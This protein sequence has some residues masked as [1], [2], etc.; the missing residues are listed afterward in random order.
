MWERAV[1]LAAVLED[2]LARLGEAL[3]SAAPGWLALG[4]VLHLAN[5]VARGRGWYA[6]VSHACDGSGPPRRRDAVA[7]WIAGAGAGGVL[8]ARGGDAVRVYLLSRRAPDP[9]CAV[10]TGTLVAEAAGELT[11]GAVIVALAAYVGT[12]VGAGSPVGALAAAA[13]VALAVVAL[14]VLARRSAR[15]RRVA[16]RVGRGCALLRTPR[17]YARHVLPWQLLSRLCRLAALACFLT[18]FGLPAT[19]AAVVLI[20]FAQGGARLL[21]L[22]PA[23]VGA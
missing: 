2:A 6:I 9:G 19:P 21:P 1:D 15:V 13:A 14:G 10:L 20:A 4:V 5:Q 7:A 22:A 12:G 11:V 17:G 18:A 3:A 23:S 8:S 16:R